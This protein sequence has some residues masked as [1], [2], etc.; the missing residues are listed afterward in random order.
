MVAER[1]RVE[2]DEKDKDKT[3]N[4]KERKKLLVS[5]NSKKT[6]FPKKRKPTHAAN[7]A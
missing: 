5:L 2:T 7:Q 1:G 4:E 3:G 6:R